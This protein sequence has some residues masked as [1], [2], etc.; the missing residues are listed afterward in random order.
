M[1]APLNFGQINSPQLIQQ[2]GAPEHDHGILDVARLMFSVQ[3]ARQRIAMEKQ[4]ITLEAQRTEADVAQSTQATAESKQRVKNQQLEFEEKMADLEAADIA[5][6]HFS[7]LVTM[8]G[9]ITQENVIAARTSLVASVD[10]KMLSRVLAK[11]EPTVN[12]A[13][14][15]LTSIAQQRTARTQAR[16]SEAVAPAAIS[17][18]NSRAAAANSDAILADLRVKRDP[19]RVDAAV[20][21]AMRGRVPW[22]IARQAAGLGPGGMPEEFVFPQDKSA[23]QSQLE[24]IAQLATLGNSI[25]E[26]VGDIPVTE[27]GAVLRQTNSALVDMALNRLVSPQQRQLVQGY[28]MLGSAF[29]RYISGQQSTDREALRLMNM[30]ATSPG[31]D[32]NTRQQKHFVRNAVVATLNQAAQGL[33]DPVQAM[34]TIIEAASSVGASPA[35]LKELRQQRGDAMKFRRTN[36]GLSRANS[37]MRGTAANPVDSLVGEFAVPRQ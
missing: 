12:N 17:E 2:Q 27:A 37:A 34:D 35:L 24:P 11:F 4:R 8:P 33:I 19:A 14:Q 20:Q 21:I 15:T 36:A 10:P 3:E 31:D 1:T 29:G 28:R 16:V 30:L 7:G 13:T 32:P 25:L 9:G 22:T 26:S 23:A 6:Q 18:A 5:A